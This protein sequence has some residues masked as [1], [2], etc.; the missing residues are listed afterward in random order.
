MK[1][2]IF[3]R[4]FFVFVIFMICF[5]ICSADIM[6]DNSHSVYRCAKIIKNPYLKNISLWSKITW[7]MVEEPEIKK[8]TYDTCLSKW[9]KFNSFEILL[10]KDWKTLSLWVIET[11]GW[12]IDNSN[13]LT[14]ET[15][16][17][18]VI[19][20]GQTYILQKISYE[21]DF[22]YYEKINIFKN[23]PFWVSLFLT[24]ILETLFLFILKKITNLTINN[25]KIL[26]AGF[27]CSW[28][29]LPIFWFL[30]G[31]GSKLFGS[32]ETY[33]LIWEILIILIE[34]L[35]LK[36]ILEASRK[37][38]FI[39][40]LLCNLISYLVWLS[41]LVMYISTIFIYS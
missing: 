1:L 11:W 13:P 7:P 30:K 21:S 16:T 24:I 14:Q 31:F 23:I 18:Q 22:K 39:F 15:I 27:I 20:T 10:K 28:I 25:K 41:F 29:T 32:F 34:S 17:Y 12:Y 4:L 35:I 37:N 5:S 36:F 3:K 19:Q 26:L 9:Y 38:S 33:V 40:S 8:I 2:N 6:P